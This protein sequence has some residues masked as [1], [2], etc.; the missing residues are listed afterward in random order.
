MAID[1]LQRYY[2]RHAVVDHLLADATLAA[3]SNGRIFPNRVESWLEEELTGIGV[4]VLNENIIEEKSSPERNL[5]RLSLVVEVVAQADSGLD[6]ILDEF[7]REIERLMQLDDITR[8]IVNAGGQDT[9]E[10]LGPPATEIVL[11]ESDVSSPVGVAAMTFDVEFRQPG[12]PAL[13]PE[14]GNFETAKSKFIDEK[15]TKITG[16]TGFPG[17]FPDLEPK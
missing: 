15:Q 4:Y 13:I 2:F 11:M 6:D 14:T 12:H 5:R 17:P 9:F 8:R 10:Y 1:H 7:C 16:R 3:M